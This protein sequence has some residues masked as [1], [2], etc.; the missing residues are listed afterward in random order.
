M[1][2]TL[3]PLG[4]L[5]KEEIGRFWPTFYSSLAKTNNLEQ[6]LAAARGSD[7]IPTALFFRHR[8]RRQFV[9][10]AADTGVS[11]AVEPQRIAVELTA[12]KNFMEQIR[13]IEARY[14]PA[15]SNITESDAFTKELERHKQLEDQLKRWTLPEA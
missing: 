6:S 3:V 15:A 9:P 11:Q 12:S 1:P 8:L 13:E 7:R 2:S 4:R 5:R 14:D 10:L